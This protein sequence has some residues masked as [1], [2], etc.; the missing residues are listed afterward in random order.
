MSAHPDTPGFR[1]A[2]RAALASWLVLAL[3]TLVAPQGLH[4]FDPVLPLR[5]LDQWQADVSPNWN[6]LVRVDPADL[7]QDRLEWLGWWAPGTSL[8][9]LPG[10]AAGIP[11][12]H[13]LRAV[14]LAALLAG[15]VGWSRWFARQPLPPSFL[16]ALAVSLPWMRYGS[17]NLFRYSAEALA[18]A[19]APWAFL[20]LA[21]VVR[22]AALQ[23]TAPLALLGAALGFAYWLKFS[24]FIVVLAAVAALA[25]SL[26]RTAP[27]RRALFVRIAVL[28]A[29]L[30][31]APTV[32]LLLDHAHGGVT[33]LG[34]PGAVSW[35]PAHLLSAVANPALALAD[36]FGP[37]F[38]VFV[39]PGFFGLGGHSLDAVAWLGLP[40]GL[41]LIILLG[42]A[43]RRRPAAI[44]VS[45]AA[46]ALAGL[47]AIVAALWIFAD[48]D[49]MPRHVAQ[50]SLAALP[51]ALAEG[52]HWW[53]SSRARLIRPLLAVA[54]ALYVAAPLAF[55]FCYVA[56][57][58]TQR[59]DATRSPHA[60]ALWSVPADEALPGKLRE[61]HDADPSS[62]LVVSDPE[63]SLLW[64][65]RVLWTFAGGSV[66][67]DLQ[68]SYHGVA[69]TLRWST[70][71]PVT[72]HLL[73]RPGAALP[74]PLD[75]GR[76][77]VSA[78]WRGAR[79][80]VVTGRLNPP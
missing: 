30:A 40:G 59:H 42:R 55:G 33:P 2:T 61:L 73:D 5:A 22:N 71:S 76:F 39:H 15:S 66:G 47:T 64:P 45:L 26:W 20:S 12:G 11:A 31:A 62:I 41:L 23:R 67:E 60:I 13:L 80:T 34:A 77:V 63:M 44:E 79:T 51:V 54:A 57:K 75:H 9:M 29:C 69:P 7:S 78:T 46:F 65:G 16:V 52:L 36:A 3:V 18:F 49:R 4:F 35:S 28:A 50:V 43:V 48:V 17:S 56:T 53:R 58:L 21:A 38:F 25:C 70:S 74:A 8:L 10:L 14:A 24:L 32:W 68:N 6:T 72:L 19:A 1:L 27:N 37:F